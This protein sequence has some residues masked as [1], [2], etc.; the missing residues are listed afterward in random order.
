M[1]QD[2]YCI[3]CGLPCTDLCSIEPGIDDDGNPYRHAL[4]D[5]F[6]LCQIERLTMRD[7]AQVVAFMSRLN[8]SFQALLIALDARALLVLLYWL[9]ILEKLGL[10]WAETR[11]AQEAQAIIEYLEPNEDIKIRN[12]LELPRMTFAHVLE[13]R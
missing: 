3:T 5:L 7:M 2:G 11:A 1:E 9:A 13:N 8:G 10:W 6:A 4:M 12:L